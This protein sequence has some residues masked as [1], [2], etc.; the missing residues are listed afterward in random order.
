MLANSPGYGND[1]VCRMP[2]AVCRAVQCS[3][4]VKE[5]GR[6]G[7]GLS[8]AHPRHKSCTVE[9]IVGCFG[10]AVAPS[11]GHG[12]ERL[13]QRSRVDGY[14]TTLPIPVAVARAVHVDSKY[15]LCT[16][17]SH[18]AVRYQV[19]AI[20]LISKTSRIHDGHTLVL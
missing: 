20:A 10:A 4:A 3:S 2:Y 6:H 8:C 5:G 14:S 16:V 19:I 17:R 15:I 9:Y 1:A 13:A 7:D 12:Q 18:H 11:G